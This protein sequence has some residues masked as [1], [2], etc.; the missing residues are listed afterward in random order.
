MANIE[1]F[2]VGK[3]GSS[4][5]KIKEKVIKRLKRRL[6]TILIVVVVL[7]AAIGWYFYHEAN[8]VYTGFDVLNSV[9]YSPADGARMVSLED[10]V[11]TY[12]KDGAGAVDSQGNRLWN[13]TF[14]MQSPMASFDGYT[15]AFA[16][17]NGNNIFMQT[18]KEA[19]IEV[20]TSMPIRNIAVSESGLVAAVLDDVDV[21][22]IYL[23]DSKGDVIAQFRS[24]MEKSGYPI[25]LDISPSG[26]LVAV[27]FYYVD[28]NDIKSSVA[29][30]NFGDVGQNQIDNLV[31]SYNYTNSVVPVVR[32]VSDEKVFALSNGRLSFYKGEHKPVSVNEVFFTDE[33]LS[34]FYDENYVA[35]VVRNSDD[36]NRYRAEIYS[37]DGELLCKKTFEFDYSEIV[38]G[39]DQFV[40]YG[41]SNLYVES[42]KGKTR[43][44]G[45]YTDNIRLCIPDKASNKFVVVTGNS[46]DTIQLK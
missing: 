11:L 18:E 5:K 16:D 27:S 1:N 20:K 42:V 22:Y 46:I 15:A 37:T 43:F 30:Y 26:E 44:D 19:N 35:V 6:Y 40:I 38:F 36:A 39:Y 3:E 41:G 34:V 12:S 25:D 8:K 17:Y 23:Y 2:P 14:D 31:S 29:F 33:I 10:T 21:T 13:Q 9:F 24:T 28:A 45:T 32:F 4:Q 7:A